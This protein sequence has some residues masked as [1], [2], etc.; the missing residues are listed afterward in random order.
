M[1]DDPRRQTMGH[2][3]VIPFRS[4]PSPEPLDARLRE[5]FRDVPVP[6]LSDA[7]GR[8]N[9]M[10]AGLR[11]LDP[12]MPRLLGTAVTVRLQPGDNWALH[13][14]LRKVR[15]GDVLVVDWQGYRDGCGSGALSLAAAAERGLAGVVIDGCWRDVEDV[16]EVGVPVIARGVS[17]FS[18]SKREFGEIN[19]PA[20]CGGVIVQPGDLVVGDG[21][22]V[23]VVPRASVARVAEVLAE[24]AA[25]PAMG[26]ED[27]RGI[28]AGYES[29]FDAV[30]AAERA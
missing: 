20:A 18:P 16:L 6:D 19:V 25:K 5:A 30:F 24:R 26:L 17:P 29:T 9:T 4:L 27:V 13:G 10:D 1:V 3:P 15:E 28:G 14:A 11:P 7:V 2:V 22:G 23:V 21:E 12:S 8:L